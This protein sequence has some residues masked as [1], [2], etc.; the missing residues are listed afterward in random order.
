MNVI[1]L[2]F[3][4]V[5][6]TYHYKSKK[7]I[8]RRIKILSDICKDLDC[9]VVISASVKDVID[10]DTLEILDENSWV[11]HIFKCFNKYGIECIGRTPKIRKYYGEDAYTEVWKEDEILTY[12][13][14]HP[15]IEHYCVIDDNDCTD[16]EK[17]K[18]H[19]VET[20]NYS[21]NPEEEG[22][23]ERHKEE[24]AKKLELNIERKNTRKKTR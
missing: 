21:D 22:L 10:E 11:N 15:E 9:K 24:I 4:G 7:D 3:D 14:A 6:D 2:D 19:L 1:F 13:D 23:L 5:L 8:E 18:D 12:L 16:L 20:L 17:V